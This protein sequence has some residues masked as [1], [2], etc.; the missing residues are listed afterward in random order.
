MLISL[1][2][3]CTTSNSEKR[4]NKRKKYCIMGNRQEIEF[5]VP[6]NLEYGRMI[7]TRKKTECS[8]Y[9]LIWWEQSASPLHFEIIF[10]GSIDPVSWLDRVRQTEKL[11]LKNRIWCTSTHRTLTRWGIRDAFRQ[12]QRNKLGG[13]NI[14]WYWY[15]S[16]RCPTATDLIENTQHL[17]VA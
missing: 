6:L 4:L 9:A 10:L 11:E 1:L 8:P 14:E 2:F 3:A 13:N 16:Q 12:T 7:D 17:S 15:P 5:F